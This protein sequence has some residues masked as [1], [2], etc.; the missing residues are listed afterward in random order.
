[1][2]IIIVEIC[3]TAIPYGGLFSKQKI[4]KRRQ[5]LNF[6]GFSFILAGVSYFIVPMDFK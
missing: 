5:H 6:E 3:S 1:M 4:L 2:G